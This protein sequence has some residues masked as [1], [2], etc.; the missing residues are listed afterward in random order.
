MP[1][2]VSEPLCSRTQTL[3]L[4]NSASLK[5]GIGI[6]RKECVLTP[7]TECEYLGPN[8][9]NIHMMTALESSA[10]VDLLMPPYLNTVCNYFEER[11]LQSDLADRKNQT[12]DELVELNELSECNF[13]VQPFN[14]VNPFNNELNSI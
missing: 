12:T 3:V 7:S 4:T 2:G 11:P 1:M 6:V 13:E 14:S 9:G 8:F 5:K 10:V